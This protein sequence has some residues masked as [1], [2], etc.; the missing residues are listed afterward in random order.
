MWNVIFTTIPHNVYIM[1]HV[2][3]PTAPCQME[4]SYDFLTPNNVMLKPPGNPNDLI[5]PTAPG[6]TIPSDTSK[7]YIK[8]VLS[9]EEAI[10]LGSL[11][12]LSHPPP[13]E[14]SVRFQLTIKPSPYIFNVVVSVLSSHLFNLEPVVLTLNSQITVAR[15]KFYLSSWCPECR[16]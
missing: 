9:S 16:P 12:L 4:M 15:I 6:L 13:P 2:C 1:C 14:G 3:S 5:D 8:V 11:S 10:E 7:P